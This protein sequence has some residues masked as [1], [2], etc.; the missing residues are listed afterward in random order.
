MS[1]EIE[2]KAEVSDLEGV[3]CRLLSLGAAP[4]RS[5]LER[6]LCFDRADGALRK[7]D[8]L[9]RLRDYHGAVLTFKGPR[10]DAAAAVK[11]RVEIETPV[12]DFDAMSGILLSAGFVKAWAYE[13]RRQ[14]WRLRE[15]KVCLDEAP[16]LGTFVEIEHVD[17]ERALETLDELGIARVHVVPKTYAELWAARAGTKSWPMPDMTFESEE[18]R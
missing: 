12:G 4:G 2:V 1:H 8:S 3:R 7:S 14:E 17:A 18:T 16:G 9:L 6:N 5:G 13:K 15:A 10:G 11:S